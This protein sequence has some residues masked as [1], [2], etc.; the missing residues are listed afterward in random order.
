KIT[1]MLREAGA[2]E[3]HIRVA[4]PPILYPDF[5]GINTPTTAQLLASGRSLEEVRE[6]IGA[7]SLAFLSLD[8]LYEAIGSGPRDSKDPA[9]TDH[10]FTG[11]YPTRLVDQEAAERHA[12]IE[13]LSFLAETS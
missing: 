13:Q 2:R 9:F 1:A 8:G 5:Y 4:C 6:K 11:E 3:V 7:D 10:C 12:I